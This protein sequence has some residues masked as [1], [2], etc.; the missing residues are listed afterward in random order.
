MPTIHKRRLVSGVVV[1][2]LTHGTGADRQRFPVGTTHEQAQEAFGARQKW[3]S[4]ALEK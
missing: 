3:T 4:S 2:E 1:W